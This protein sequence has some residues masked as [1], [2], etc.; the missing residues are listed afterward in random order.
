MTS[1]SIGVNTEFGGH[2]DRKWGQIYF[3]LTEMNGNG[4]TEMG[5]DLFFTNEC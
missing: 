4:Q 3:S 2:H 5:T 1:Q